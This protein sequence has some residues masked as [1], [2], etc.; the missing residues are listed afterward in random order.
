MNTKART[1]LILAAIFGAGLASGVLLA[2]VLHGRDRPQAAPRS[3]VD[4]TMDRLEQKLRLTP[5]QRM[6]VRELA[7]ESG[8]E[9][10]K[11]RRDSWQESMKAIQRL[12]EKIAALLT[13]EQRIQFDDFHR[14]QFE[15]LRRRQMD[16]EGRYGFRGDG[17][18][19]PPDG[20]P[21]PADGGA[22]LPP[23]PP[24]PAEN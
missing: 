8:V 20:P 21:P 4:R 6:Q 17:P 12:N 22:G 19:P 7:K 3:F 14:E 1:I 2:P 13:P 5:E 15:R 18:P 24:P 10:G 16:R 9:L 11:I 23:P